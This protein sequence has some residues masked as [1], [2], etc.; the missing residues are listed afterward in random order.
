M[1]ALCGRKIVHADKSMSGGRRVFSAVR[2]QLRPT[3]RL[4]MPTTLVTDAAA[5]GFHVSSA[6]ISQR[7]M[8][9][10]LY[11]VLSRL[12]T[13]RFNGPFSRETRVS[14]CQKARILDFNGAQGLNG[15]LRHP[16]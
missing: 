6:L 12:H 11:L 13:K 15:R 9:T 8:I 5:I 1:H 2:F 14:R 7:R 3:D 10:V 16:S 4:L